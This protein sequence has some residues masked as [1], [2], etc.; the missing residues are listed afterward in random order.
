M[1]ELLVIIQV[2]GALQMLECLFNANRLFFIL[3]HFKFRGKKWWR[4]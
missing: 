1:C 4:F 3:S 2:D